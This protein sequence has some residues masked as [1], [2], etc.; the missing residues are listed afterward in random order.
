[1][2]EAVSDSDFQQKVLEAEGAVIVDFW[3]PWCGPC[4]QM[5]PILEELDRERDDVRVVAL[6]I[7]EN[8]ATPASYGVM[9]IPTIILFRDGAEQ[10]RVI[11]TLPKHRLLRELGLG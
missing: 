7:D 3:A 4:R 1:M 11:G 6:N 5:H 10:A 9:S 2:L 8:Q